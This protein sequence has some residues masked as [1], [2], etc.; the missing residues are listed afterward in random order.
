MEITLT[1]I[2]K[3]YND[4]T[5]KF[6]VPRQG[7]LSDKLLSRIVF[8]KKYRNPDALRGIE[9]YSHLWLLWHLSLSP[10]G[11][12][13]PTVRPPKLGGNKRVGVF[14]TRSPNRP[15]P[16]GLTCVKLEK[17]IDDEKYGKVLVVSGA[18][19]VNG[20]EI[21][22]IKPYLT[23]CDSK[24][25]A[26]NGF[27]LCETKGALEV[28]FPE[29]LEKLIPQNKLEGLV[30]A[31]SQDPRPGYQKDSDRIY[32]MPFAELEISFTVREN[33]LFVVEIH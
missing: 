5:T 17:I 22:D 32:V 19:L 28:E 21:F 9:E 7:G 31:L 16:L 20:T 8:E 26:K 2:A 30:Q 15:N 33:R 23:Y 14:A 29:N 13:Y 12:F 27:A 25:E 6:G 3:I 18:D 24:P 10:K 11:E 4:F 1:P